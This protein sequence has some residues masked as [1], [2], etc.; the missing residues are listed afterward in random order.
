[1]L[2]S[3]NGEKCIFIHIPKT[4]GNTI[5]KALLDLGES[6]DEIKVS[7]HQ[8]G[9]DR[10]EI[11]GTYT[12]KKHMR[13]AEYLKHEDLLSLN[14][15]S[16]VRRPLQRLVS[17]YFSP[18]RHIQKDVCKGDWHIPSEV[19]FDIDEFKSLIDK[20]PTCLDMLSIK[21]NN[22][23]SAIP[24]KIKIMRTE[25]LKDDCKR[26]LGLDILRSSNVSPY[27]IEASLACERRDV[28]SLVG[29]SR[30]AQDE[31]FFYSSS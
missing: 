25:N 7:G 22:G 1:M 21:L 13:V 18:H 8:D 20:T 4:G 29:S 23:L 17:L 31:T 30:H 12:T 6:F 3:Q 26:I 27:R 9:K 16:C 10:F 24:T 2:F 11:R 28:I 19:Q 5:Q 15:F 14:I